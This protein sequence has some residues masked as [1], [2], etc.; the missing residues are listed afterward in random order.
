MYPTNCLLM[1]Y[2]CIECRTS[3]CD[4]DTISLCMIDIR[5]WMCA[6]FE[7]KIRCVYVLLLPLVLLLLKIRVIWDFFRTN[8]CPCRS[9]FYLFS[10]NAKR[11]TIWYFGPW[12]TKRQKE[13]LSKCKK[14]LYTQNGFYAVTSEPSY[15]RN[16]GYPFTIASPYTHIYIFAMRAWHINFNYQ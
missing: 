9:R 16:N 5:P 8:V 7:T 4:C 10:Y 12:T 3:V 1:M 11:K 6:S 14:N 2:F 13:I 15:I